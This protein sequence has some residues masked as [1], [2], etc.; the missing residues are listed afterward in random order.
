MS[1]TKRYS[2]LIRIVCGILGLLGLGAIAFNY[3]H[4]GEFSFSFL[5]FAQ[6]FAIFLFIYVAI[7]GVSPIEDRLKK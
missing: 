5:L 6:L 7:W 4:T 1:E 2:K 3:F